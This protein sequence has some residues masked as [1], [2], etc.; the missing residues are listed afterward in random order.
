MLINLGMGA[1][2]LHFTSEHKPPEK[3]HFK[4]T[5]TDGGGVTIGFSWFGYIH[6]VS[7]ES[8][9]R[10]KMTASLGISP[11]DKEFTMENFDKLLGKREAR[12]KD[13]LIDQKNIAGIGNVYI[14][15]TLFKAKLH[16]QRKI[17]AL[18]QK[19]KNELYNAI[20]DVLDRAIQIGGLAYEE[21][22]YGRKGGLTIDEFL[23]GYKPGKPC[24]T[25]G[26]TIEKIKTGSTSSYICPKC[27]TL[28]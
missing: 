16:P 27:Q 1:K 6:L 25:C 15:D 20:R 3:C 10:H 8:L 26:T 23:V 19:E 28:K 18:S 22:F 17:S 7:E 11:L 14:Q 12:V 2:L 21:D 13:F 5:F 4:M 9:T 24:P